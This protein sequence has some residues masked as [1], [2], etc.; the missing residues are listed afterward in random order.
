MKISNSDIL[1]FIPPGNQAGAY[2]PIAIVYSR[3][4]MSIAILDAMKF[5]KQK[6]L[7]DNQKIHL[8]E[9]RKWTSRYKAGSA[10]I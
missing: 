2:N 7:D 6:M 4:E 3:M 1:K 9:K 10:G 8:T 5:V